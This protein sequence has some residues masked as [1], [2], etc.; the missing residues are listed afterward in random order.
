MSY[1]KNQSPIQIAAFILTIFMVGIILYYECL[2]IYI[3]WIHAGALN[4]TVPEKVSTQG[5]VALLFAGGI[6]FAYHFVLYTRVTKEIKSNERNI[7]QFLLACTLLM[8][9]LMAPTL[10]TAFTAYAYASFMGEK[11]TVTAMHIEIVFLFLSGIMSILI[12]ILR[13]NVIRRRNYPCCSF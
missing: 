8:I 7:Y 11:M 13:R 6:G 9:L 5:W 2:G 12:P 3:A 1:F 4:I 10:T